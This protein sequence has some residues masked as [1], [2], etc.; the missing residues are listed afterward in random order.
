MAVRKNKESRTF[1]EAA[2]AGPGYDPGYLTKSVY[3][4]HLLRWSEIFAR[5]QML[6]LKSEAFFE[7]PTETLEVVLE[8]LGLPEWEPEA[9]EI[10][11]KRNEGGYEQERYATLERLET[12]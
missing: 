9:Q 6:T 8:F 5:E 4:D 1:E 12:P 2:E 10:G 3:V 7:K 11:G